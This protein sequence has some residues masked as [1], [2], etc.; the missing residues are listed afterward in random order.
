MA[1]SSSNEAWLCEKRNGSMGLLDPSNAEELLG[2][3]KVRL[4]FFLRDNCVALS[5]LQFQ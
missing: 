3:L 4:S 1:S 5:D 2:K